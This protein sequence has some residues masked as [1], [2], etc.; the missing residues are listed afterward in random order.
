MTRCELS[1]RQ[2]HR[3]TPLPPSRGDR[4]G[5]VGVRVRLL[6]VDGVVRP[7]DLTPWSR[8]T[9]APLNQRVRVGHRTVHHDDLSVLALPPMRSAVPAWSRATGAVEGDVPETGPS[10]RSER[11][12]DSDPSR[13]VERTRRVLTNSGR[14]ALRPGSGG[15]G[16]GSSPSTAPSRRSRAGTLNALGGKRARPDRHEN[17]SVTTEA[18]GFK[19]GALS[20]LD[21]KVKIAVVRHVDWQQSNAYATWPVDRRAGGSGVN[22]SLPPTT[23][24]LTGVI[25]ASRPPGSPAPPVPARTR[26]QRIQR[27]SAG[28]ST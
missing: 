10:A 16:L 5:H 19:R 12:R 23:T 1:F 26:P 8:T 20:V 3:L 13:T 9:R 15:P 18:A 7:A 17:G 24:S 4:T 21:G 6:P 2:G 14:I 27:S 28:T 11:S 22:V 25:S